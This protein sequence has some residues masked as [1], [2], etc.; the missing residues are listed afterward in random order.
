MRRFSSRRRSASES[1]KRPAVISFRFC[2]AGNIDSRQRGLRQRNFIRRATF[3]PNCYRKTLTVG[4]CH[5]RCALATIGME[6]PS[7]LERSCRHRGLVP[8]SRPS[9]SSPPGRVR[10]PSKRTPLSSPCSF[11]RLVEDKGSSFGIM[12]HA[13]PACK[14]SKSSSMH[15]G[16]GMAPSARVAHP[17]ACSASS[18]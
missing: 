10:D 15:T 9:T 4:Q 18:L 14:L 6:L 17:L 1:Y 13:A 11:R 16:F 12:R 2:R 5:P 7:W 3:P 8:Y